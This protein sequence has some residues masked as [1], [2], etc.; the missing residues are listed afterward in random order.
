MLTII[1][2]VVGLIVGWNF[3]PQPQIVKTQIDKLVAKFKGN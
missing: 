1:S 2:F 3:V